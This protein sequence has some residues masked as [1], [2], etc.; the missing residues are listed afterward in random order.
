MNGRG[1]GKNVFALKPN[2]TPVRQGYGVDRV[3]SGGTEMQSDNS[4]SRG[5]ATR[6]FAL[7]AVMLS[8]ASM[9]GAQGLAWLSQSG[10]VSVVAYHAPETGGQ[11][12]VADMRQTGVADVGVDTMPTGSIGSTSVMIRIR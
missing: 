8:A 1:S 4:N 6:W 12:G 10:R 2:A 11:G 9:L 7:A 5:S 3:G